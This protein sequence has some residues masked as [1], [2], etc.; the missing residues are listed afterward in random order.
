VYERVGD[1][2]DIVG[3]VVG[4]RRDG[5]ERIGAGQLVA[6]GVVRERGPGAEGIG[7]REQPTVGFPGPEGGR[8]VELALD[9]AVDCPERPSKRMSS[10][11]VD[12][13]ESAAFRIASMLLAKGSSSRMKR[14]ASST[15]RDLAASS[16]R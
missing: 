5:A 16:F 8:A 14:Y 1:R 10:V 4:V 11:V 9:R 12:I 13:G 3:R 6:A 2:R 7:E 15:M